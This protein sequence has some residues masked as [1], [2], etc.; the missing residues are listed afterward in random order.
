M[1][2]S[3]LEDVWVDS[4]SLGPKTAEH[5]LSGHSYAKGIGLHKLTMQAM[6]RILT[7][8]LLTFIRNR[9]HD[10]EK[11]IQNNLSSND[12]DG[13][14]SLVANKDFR[15]TVDA[16]VASN[17]NPNF[18]FWWTY[19]E[20]V[21]ILLLFIRAQTDGLWQLHLH[22]FKLIVP[23]FYRYNHTNYAKWGTV[24]ISEMN[25]LP[26][27]VKAL[28]ESGNFVVKRSEKQFNQVDPYQS[29]EWLNAIGKNVGLEQVDPLIGHCVVDH[30]PNTS[31]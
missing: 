9:D 7:Q 16:F 31:Q 1:H 18:Q 22:A 17:D 11:E 23:F 25:H 27:E 12:I 4:N 30:N 2:S 14:V 28:F 13:V 6:W 15:E 8:K 21:Q 24:Y 3:E 29:Q 26:N 5:A 19:V 10:L 20:M